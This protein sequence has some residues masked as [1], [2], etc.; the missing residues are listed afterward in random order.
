[1]TTTDIIQNQLAQLAPGE[2][3]TVLGM[4]VTR[5]NQFDA[6]EVDGQAYPGYGTH[7]L[8]DA[9]AC[10]ARQAAYAQRTEALA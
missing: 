7:A 1:M 8:A 5:K 3:D 6:W 2:T 4:A 10:R 9:L